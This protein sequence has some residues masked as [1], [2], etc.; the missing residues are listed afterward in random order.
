MW[1][2]PSTEFPGLFKST[3]GAFGVIEEHA[4]NTIA[5]SGMMAASPAFSAFMHANAPTSNDSAKPQIV[6]APHK[7][8]PPA[9][10]IDGGAANKRDNPGTGGA[11]PVKKKDKKGK[12]KADKAV[13]FGAPS[14]GANG[15]QPGS[16]GAPSVNTDVNQP[17]SF[18]A[19]LRPLPDPM[20]PAPSSCSAAVTE[21]SAH[22]SI[23]WGKAPSPQT[24]DKAKMAKA[25]GV[26]IAGMCAPCVM[27]THASRKVRGSLCTKPTDPKHKAGAKAVAHQRPSNFGHQPARGD[28]A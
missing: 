11:G 15:N 10:T 22:C 21:T 1:T 7:P 23:L 27:S 6:L 18:K 13:A 14:T 19:I 8:P 28:F 12:S 20:N 3:Y 16:F 25:V 5:L 4:N 9:I 26:S 17:G 2:S 24:A